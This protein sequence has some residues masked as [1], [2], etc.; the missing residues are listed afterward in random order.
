MVNAIYYLAEAFYVLFCLM[1]VSTQFLSFQMP[2]PLCLSQGDVF[3][4]GAMGKG[5]PF[6]FC[7]FLL[8]TEQQLF[9]NYLLWFC[10]RSHVIYLCHKL[11]Y[12]QLDY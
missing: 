9:M 6:F 2:H 7:L 3:E 11:W 5:I 10:V 1:K 8:E 12:P 4:S